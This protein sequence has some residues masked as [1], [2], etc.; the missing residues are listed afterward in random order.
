MDTEVVPGGDALEDRLA[1]R[2]DSV[3][4]CE[5]SQHCWE[6]LILVATVAQLVPCHCCVDP[7]V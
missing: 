5:S 1:D 4:V 3:L 2:A 7:T 6:Y